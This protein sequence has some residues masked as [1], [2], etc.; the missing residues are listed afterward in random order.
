VIAWSYVDAASGQPRSFETGPV[1][2][3]TLFLELRPP[4][5]PRS[6]LVVQVV[7]PR[8]APV[9]T[10]RV[11]TIAGTRRGSLEGSEHPV[12][13]RGTA[14]LDGVGSGEVRIAVSG[15]GFLADDTTLAP[16]DDDREIVVT[17]RRIATIRLSR[18]PDGPLEVEARTRDGA[19]AAVRCSRVGAKR[20][21]GAVHRF[22][23][24]SI[25]VL[26]GPCRLS[27]RSKGELLVEREL[28][29]AGRETVVV[30]P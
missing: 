14:V 6:R 28:D 21:D 4:R 13:A 18:F 26:E 29:L 9:K 19:W 11:R 27:I 7:D 23:G 20:V 15:K 16:G 17:V 30:Q 10:A 25:H 3:G 2:A 22:D 5:A 12:D 1:E 24:R 8:G